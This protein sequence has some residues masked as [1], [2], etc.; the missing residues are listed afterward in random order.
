[1][2][3]RQVQETRD[4]VLVLAH[5]S[6]LRRTTGRNGRLADLDYA[7]L[8]QLDAGSWFS[9]E[10][11]GEPVPTLQ[12][13]VEFCK[14]RIFMNIE[15]KS[16]GDGSALPERVAALVEE[17]DMLEQCVITSTSLKYL[18]R[19]KEANPEIRT[20]YIVSAAYGDYYKE[21]YV[22]FIS[23]LSTS[24]SARLVLSLIHI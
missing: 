23:M 21:E 24:L 10:Y 5:D 4:G 20:G 17:N 9:K 3:K 6:S 19:V 11:A 16:L 7:E 18:R 22:D 14:G 15:L 2:Y 13:A 1:M 8:A 12:E